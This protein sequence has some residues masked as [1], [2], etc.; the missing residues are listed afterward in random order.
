[1]LYIVS[2]PIGN[3]KDIT[4]RAIDTLKEVDLIL[5]EDT[6]RTGKLLKEY[7]ID[8]KMLSYNDKNKESRTKHALNVLEKG[9]VAVVSDSGTPG[10][11]DPG[12]YIV[13][14][15]VKNDVQ[16]SPIPGACA[17][18][19]GLVCSGL[20]TDK[21]EFYGFISKKEG[22]KR[23]FFEGLGDRT[24]VFYESPYRIVKTLELMNEVIPDRNIVIARELTKKF[25]EFI[26]GKVKE[27]YPKVKDLKGEIV[28]VLN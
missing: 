21:F 15:A 8:T 27:V 5:A 22:Q 23:K 6:R 18:I 4:L 19:A 26:R 3:M 7:Q 13:R 14:E 17:M 9:D 24:V 12:F 1:M 2:T 11:S 16:V 28:V 10:I 20:P 25:E